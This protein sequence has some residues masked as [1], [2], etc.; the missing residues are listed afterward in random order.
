MASGERRKQLRVPAKGGVRGK[1][2]TAA[3][4][5]VLDL[6]MSGALLEVP[7]TLKVGEI[8]TLRL[9]IRPDVLAI[10][11]KVVRSYVHGFDK[12]ERG[13]MVIKYRAA[14][15]FLDLSDKYQTLIGS[16]IRGVDKADLS[17]NLQSDKDFL[18]EEK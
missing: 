9:A 7:C 8:Y 17:A 1:I 18:T 15:Q 14:I 16:Y 6:S 5:P 3:S 13:E 10:K 4:V 12:N 2:H 11:S